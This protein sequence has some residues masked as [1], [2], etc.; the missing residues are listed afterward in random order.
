MIFN[1]ISL[2]TNK[3]KYEKICR[4]FCKKEC[5][6][7]KKIMFIIFKSDKPFRKEKKLDTS[8]QIPNDFNKI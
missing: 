8:I 4:H 1:N 6:F 7:V 5:V 3:I 2:I